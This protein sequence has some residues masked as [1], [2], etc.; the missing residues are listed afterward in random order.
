MTIPICVVPWNSAR[1]TDAFVEQVR[2]YTTVPYRLYVS[3]NSASPRPIDGNDV[4]YWWNGRN[5]GYAKAINIALRKAPGDVVIVANLD[6]EFPRGW[7]ATL[8]RAYESTDFAIIAPLMNSRP[9]WP[10]KFKGGPVVETVWA[11]N[12]ALWITSKSRLLDRHGYWDDSFEGIGCADIYHCW[13]VWQGGGRVG[14]CTDLLIY[15]HGHEIMRANMNEKEHGRQI[16]A[17]KARLR[18][19]Y[20]P[21]FSDRK[22]EG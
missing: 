1:W 18:G 9:Q 16:E 7:L 2:R 11:P 3:D 17:A 5:L 15:H 22:P 20:G 6:I 19:I 13:R 10:H 8:L 4:D 21:G 12:L 14:I